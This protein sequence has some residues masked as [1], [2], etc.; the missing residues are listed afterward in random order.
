VPV[1]GDFDGDR[2]A[3]LVIYETDTSIWTLLLSSTGYVP[4]NL[5]F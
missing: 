4:I 1:P 5:V 2:I 3:D